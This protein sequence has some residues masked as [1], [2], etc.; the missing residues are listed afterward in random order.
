MALTFEMLKGRVSDLDSHEQIPYTKYAEVFG[1]RGKRFMEASAE[2][3]RIMNA[4][5]G[6]DHV[7]TLAITEDDG[8]ITEQ[9]VW[10]NKGT[11]A[12]SH[13]D[14]DRRPA[15]MD[16][17]GIQ[18]Q[19]VFPTMGL[20]ALSQAMGGRHNFSSE[21]EKAVAWDALDA[22]N[23][24]A[25]KLTSKF[26]GRMWIAAVLKS[27]KP[28]ATADGLAAEAAHLIKLGARAVFIPTGLPPAD[29]RPSDPALDK[30]YA[31]LAEANVSLVTHPPGGT[32]FTSKAW[33]PGML[34]G[35]NGHIAEENFIASLVMGGVFHRHPTLRFGVVE[36]GASWI[37]PLAEYL[38]FS[39]DP[40]RA[41]KTA[42]QATRKVYDLPMK[43]SEYINRNVRA[44]PH[45]FEP[46]EVWFER[47]PHLQDVYC[48]ST[49]YP[50]VE[51]QQYS[52]KR[53]YDIVAPLGDKL[54]EKFFV[55]NAELLLPA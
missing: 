38:D 18:R 53:Y 16:M 54:V 5:R 35:I 28:G 48:Y 32:G 46:V 50:H 11:T 7:D 22:Y 23:E 41:P 14:M 47:Y 1:D 13:A 33:R 43:P 6:A 42:G 31:T 27:A 34:S 49:D 26:P 44:N 55:T 2:L 4:R 20:L 52:L 51:G 8:E 17:M 45:N 24:W 36:C 9:T 25:C 21:E 39:A 15:V 3:F 12:P 30:F 10:E 29:L 40:A 19:L 37:G